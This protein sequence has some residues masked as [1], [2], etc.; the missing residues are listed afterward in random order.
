LLILRKFRY[1]EWPSLDTRQMA[2]HFLA[3]AALRLLRPGPS[4]TPGRFGDIYKN[5]LLSTLR[6][7]ATTTFSSSSRLIHLG[8]ANRPPPPSDGRRLTGQRCNS[9]PDK[10]LFP[11][12]NQTEGGLKSGRAVLVIVTSFPSV[13]F[14]LQPVRRENEICGHSAIFTVSTFDTKTADYFDP[15]RKSKRPF[16]CLHRVNTFSDKNFTFSAAAVES[17]RRRTAI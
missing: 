10:R 6:C 1:L 7:G 11:Q 4:T 3:T 2:D 14:R 15:L 12:R 5:Q 16:S 8:R 9:Q 13:L 17:Y